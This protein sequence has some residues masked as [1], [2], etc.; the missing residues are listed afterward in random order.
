MKP[1]LPLFAA[2]LLSLTSS[3]HAADASPADALWEKVSAARQAL[4]SPTKQFQNKEEAKEY[5][6]T[7][8]AA[9]DAAYSELVEKFPTDPRRWSALLFESQTNSSREELG[10]PVREGSKDAITQILN[11]PDADNRT[12]SEAS[13]LRVMQEETNDGSTA[14]AAAWEKLAAEHLEKYPLSPRNAMI[15]GLLASSQL[16]TPF[17][18][19]PLDLKFTA[20]DGREVDLETLRG[21]V[22]L[23]DFW[24]TWCGPCV[25][26]LPHVTKAYEKFHDKGF[27]V[28][29]I[30]LDQDRGVLE[31]F[32]R[33]N[34][35]KWPQHFDGK[36]GDGELCKRFGI[37]MIP[38]M[39]L[40]NKQG[41][42]VQ[43]NARGKVESEVE[44]LLAE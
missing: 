2:L 10:V 19:K 23:I 41:L 33:Q 6:K 35:L 43:T 26:E 9:Y 34:N 4:T 28:V 17:R 12:K 22:V 16:T 5:Y 7:S 1:A 13:A 8:I 24:A 21:K 11:A 37:Q 14:S 3:L 44:R 31:T 29:A 38:V 40:I 20:L 15:K 39:W 25:E 32:V 27:E 42:L 36:G 30:S 18:T